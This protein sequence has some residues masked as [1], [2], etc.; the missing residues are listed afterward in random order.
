MRRLRVLTWHI[1]GSYLFYLAHAPHEFF[2]P[3]KADRGNGYCGRAGTFPWP[4]N[5]HAVPVEHVRYLSLDCVLF[6]SRQA[7]VLDQ[8]D[9]L[10]PAQRR[11]PAVYLEHDPPREH[12]TDTRHVVNDPNVLLVHVTRF[13]ALMWD[14]GQSPVRVIPHG[15]VVPEQARY[16]GELARGIVVI[17]KLATRG[18]RLGADLFERARREVPLD[19]I[20]MQADAVG[21][22]DEVDPPAVPG[23]IAPYRLFFHPA[24]Y[25]SLGLAVCE[26]MMVGLPIV[27]LA[28][29]ELVS[30]VH[31]GVSGYTSTDPRQL[32]QAMQ[33]LLADR[34]EARRLGDGARQFALEHFNIQRF[35]RDWS[36][37][38]L[39]AVGSRERI[40]TPA[41]A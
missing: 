3:V 33:D 1:H 28:T 4:P 2:L 5:V 41:C 10:S 21:G 7:Y 32:T 8:F 29:T 31:N 22:L 17:N 39:E 19:L 38:L 40:F 30:T 11:L 23:F 27:G 36:E 9:I 14:S 34:A 37:V 25:T 35:A 26:A 12:P 15:V 6:Q 16:T 13:N 24:R 18:R 20:G